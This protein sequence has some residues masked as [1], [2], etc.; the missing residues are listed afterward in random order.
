MSGSEV[1]VSP[2]DRPQCQWQCLKHNCSYINYD[3]DSDQ[4]DIGLGQCESLHNTE[5]EEVYFASGAARTSS[6]MELLVLV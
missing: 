2:V 3:P 4:C 1:I 6:T 5:T